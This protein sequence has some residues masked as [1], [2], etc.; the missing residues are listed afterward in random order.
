MTI[1]NVATSGLRESAEIQVYNNSLVEER[2]H[3]IKPGVN[4]PQY[5]IQILFDKKVNV[6][7]LNYKWH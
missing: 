3:F 2:D 7:K 1:Y 4:P 6:L 5:Y